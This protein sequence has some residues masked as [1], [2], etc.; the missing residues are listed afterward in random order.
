MS[1]STKTTPINPALIVFGTPKGTRGPRAAW[2]R[3][4][5]ADR[6]TSAA[7]RQGLATVAVGS[8][9][10]RAAAGVLKEG[11]L[12][13][14]GQLVMPC[15]SQEVVN[16][17]RGLIPVLAADTV[18]TTV[19]GVQVPASIWDTL[20]PT[21]I[22]LAAWLDKAG[23][24]DGWYEATIMNIQNGVY[25]LRWLYNGKEL[26]VRLKRQHVALMFPG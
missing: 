17:L 23:D 2:F 20:K 9:E 19:P 26:L 15:V 24:P 11:Q 1:T 4:E 16:R 6:V 3:A 22:V 21:D 14:G 18:G 8:N 5:Y 10:T 13:V 12:K 25:T 7:Q